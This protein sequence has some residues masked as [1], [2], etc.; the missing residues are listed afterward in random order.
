MIQEIL[1]LGTAGMALGTA[2]F[3]YAFVTDARGRTYNALLVGIAGLAALMYL[4]M[5]LRI[6]TVYEGGQRV[7]DLARYGQWILATPLIVVYLG[8]LAGVGRKTIAGLV[9]LDVVVMATGLVGSLVEDPAVKWGVFAVGCVVYVPFLYGLLAGIRD[10]VAD[11]PPAVRAL[12]GKLRNLTVVIWTFYPVLWAL[13]PTGVGVLDYQTEVLLVTY[14]DFIAKVGF[15]V[16]AMNSQR[17]L[18]ELP[19]I[20]AVGGISF[21]DS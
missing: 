12:F 11:R 2:V 20:D 3:L 8:L 15:G 1:Y 9:V 14:A 6:G 21:T 7:D 13:G 5:S 10:A 16:I 4:L 18:A 17:A 19:R